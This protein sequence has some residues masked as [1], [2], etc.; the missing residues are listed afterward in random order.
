LEVI[1]SSVSQ[2][3]PALLYLFFDAWRNK[4]RV[5]FSDLFKGTQYANDRIEITTYCV[6]GSD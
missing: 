5:L 2:Y 3:K 1:F 4:G 6:L